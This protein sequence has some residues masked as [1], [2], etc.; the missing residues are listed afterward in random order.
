[1]L[2]PKK[3]SSISFVIYQKA[4]R[5]GLPS[6][7]IEED[8]WK[9][10]HGINTIFPALNVEGV[11]LFLQIKMVRVI[12]LAVTHTGKIINKLLMVT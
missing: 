4:G 2:K 11:I 10:V 7:Y 12:A 9:K 3:L 5:S 1:M 6:F 8:I